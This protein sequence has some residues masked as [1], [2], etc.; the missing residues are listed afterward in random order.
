[1]VNERPGPLRRYTCRR[2]AAC[3]FTTDAGL[4]IP[5]LAAVHGATEEGPDNE[6]AFIEHAEPGDSDPATAARR[7]ELERQWNRMT[8]CDCPIYGQPRAGCPCHDP[9]RGVD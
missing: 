4:L 7:S 3:G 5:H 9:E 6:S 1:M 8:R 2:Y